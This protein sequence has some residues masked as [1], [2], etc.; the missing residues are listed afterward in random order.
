[1][2]DLINSPVDKYL[3]RNKMGYATG[4][5]IVNLSEHMYN[6]FIYNLDNLNVN[7]VDRELI[8]TRVLMMIRDR[9]QL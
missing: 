1:M 7:D 8:L 3:E 4:K 5:L 6:C 9:N 2:E